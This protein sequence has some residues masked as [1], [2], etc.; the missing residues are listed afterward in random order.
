MVNSKPHTK[1]RAK[2]RAQRDIPELWFE[3]N[4][5]YFALTLLTSRILWLATAAAQLSGSCQDVAGCLTCCA[6][7]QLRPGWNFSE[8]WCKHGCRAE[9]CDELLSLSDFQSCS[10]G[11]SFTKGEVVNSKMIEAS[12]CADTGVH[13]APQKC[14]KF[15]YSS[16]SFQF[17][18]NSSSA[19]TFGDVIENMQLFF[20][21]VIALVV[22]VIFETMFFRYIGDFCP[23]LL[24]LCF[25][26]SCGLSS[27]ECWLSW[28]CLAYWFPDIWFWPVFYFV[29]FLLLPVLIALTLYFVAFPVSSMFTF[30]HWKEGDV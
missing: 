26:D 19:S 18:N 7:T 22:L 29:S 28:R 27:A 5:G 12:C 11:L 4:F 10:M 1:N 23:W 25:D 16:V 14:E 21:S 17:L 13:L 6:A 20:R 24:P 2:Q 8:N 3:M 30:I 9:T 15:E